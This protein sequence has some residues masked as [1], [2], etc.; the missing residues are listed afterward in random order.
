VGSVSF[1]GSQRS[2]QLLWRGLNERGKA[3]ADALEWKGTGK[4]SFGGAALRPFVMWV[5]GMQGRRSVA[6]RCRRNNTLGGQG[7]EWLGK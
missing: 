4:N 3:A 2:L 5:G 7:R 1:R 6:Q